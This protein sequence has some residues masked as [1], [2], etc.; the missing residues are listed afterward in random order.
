VY[1]YLQE[2]DEMIENIGVEFIDSHIKCRLPGGTG[3]CSKS[4][5]GRFLR[6][7]DSV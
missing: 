1:V 7:I 3:F 6:S 5:S 4:L 2:V